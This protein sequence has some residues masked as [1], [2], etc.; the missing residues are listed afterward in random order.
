[1]AIRYYDKALVEKITKWVKDPN[2]R[3]LKPEEVTRLFQQTA[4]INN[5]KPISLPL[6][7]I[8]REPNVEIL[9][10]NKKPLSFDGK[11]IKANY[12]KSEQ[13]D[14]IPVSI[15]YQLD[16]YTRYFTEGD[17]YVRNFIFNLINYPKLYIEI[18]YNNNKI[19][20]N[21][22][23]K[24][25]STVEDTSSIPQRLVPGQFT[26]WTIKLTIDDAY[27]FSIPIL[28]NIHIDSDIEID[29]ETE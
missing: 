11:M 8:S 10:T 3:I 1:M 6:I 9:S 5:D 21:A 22:Y 20:H 27:L 2:M 12:N 25:L 23:V 7:A 15:N 28:K 4:D 18:P 19:E 16:I 14:A 26:R 17:E 13:L 24:I 29:T